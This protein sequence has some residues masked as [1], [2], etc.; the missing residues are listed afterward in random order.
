[1]MRAYPLLILTKIF[2][3]ANSHNLKCQVQTQ[4]AKMETM[5]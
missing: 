2:V 5:N 3:Y 1:M 4:D